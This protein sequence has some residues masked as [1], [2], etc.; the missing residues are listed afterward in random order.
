MFILIPVSLLGATT[1][2]L[3]VLRVARPQFRFTW[4]I[5]L[6]ATFLA[7]ISVLI[8]RTQLPLSIS[9]APWAPAP[10]L[11]SA[12]LLAVDQFSWIY[13][14]SLLTLTIATLLTETVREGFPDSLTLAVTV[15]VCGLGLLAVTAGNPL[16]LA[17]IWAALD[18][19]ELVAML[20]SS[21]ARTAGQRVVTAFFVH[22]VAIILLMLAQVISGAAEKPLDFAS[23]A[24]QSG[25]LLLA[26]AGLRL[27]V[28]PLHLPYVPTSAR[29]RGIG[30]SI[31][32]VSAA[33]GLIL[34]SRVATPAVPSV[35]GLLILVASAA[36][37]LYSSWMWLR[38]PD[39][40][41]GRP[42][43]IIGL[44]ALSLFSAMRGNP[45]GAAAWGAALILA[46]AALFLSSVQQIWLNRLLYLGAWELSA[47]P[48]SVTATGWSGQPS[49]A[50]WGIPFF[51][52]AQA[53]LI[54]GFIRH[55]LRPAARTPLQLQPAWARSVYPAGIGLLLLVPLVLGFW[56]WDGAFQ[57]GPLF[58]G[59][60][61]SLIAAG[62]VWTVPR[63]PILNPVPAHWLGATTAASRL[64][65]ISRGLLGLYRWLAGISFTISGVLES[66]AGLM[67]TLLFLVL[68][69]IMIVQRT[70]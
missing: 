32:L 62:L 3:I 14:L 63:L 31:R 46:G 70:P 20:T 11:S 13:A 25:L 4:L 44:A 55:A 66:E 61:A 28:L 60:V 7:W 67:W 53:L 39:E 52:V 23:L 47:L 10:V 6:G 24:P 33:A 16:T 27:G 30:T 68:F 19:T 65:S 22:A 40:L 5:A 49:I 59:L 41:A 56:G 9:F 45:T 58:P 26:A 12:P 36:A 50:S 54:A 64:E 35:L 42:F 17:L 38:A 34:L 29:R 57:V 21:G 69:V 18:L 37:A 43:W 2:A 48:F 15:G 1:L 8:W 51:V